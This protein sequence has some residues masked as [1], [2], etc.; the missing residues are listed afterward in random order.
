MKASTRGSIATV[1][2]P[3]SLPAVAHHASGQEMGRPPRLIGMTLQSTV[4]PIKVTARTP[5]SKVARPARSE[6]R[7][8]RARNDLRVQQSTTTRASAAIDCTKSPWRIRCSAT[9]PASSR[10]DTSQA[11]RWPRR[12]PRARAS[13]PTPA[14][15]DE[16]SRRLADPE[17]DVAEQR[18]QPAADM[19]GHDRRDEVGQAQD[20][21]AGRGQPADP[22]QA[23][24]R[25]GDPGPH[26]AAGEGGDDG[27]ALRRFAAGVPAAKRSSKVTGRR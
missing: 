12:T 20:G 3:T 27:R 5:P 16:R 15:R 18:V 11:E 1:R 8:K 10:I 23:A 17:R 26:E 25:V 9:V 7:S 4:A 13:R 14:K 2:M 21:D 22:A 24:R 6:G 19:R